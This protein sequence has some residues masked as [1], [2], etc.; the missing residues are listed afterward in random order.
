M[1]HADAGV[2]C[3]RASNVSCKMRRLCTSKAAI[4]STAGGVTIS[5]PPQDLLLQLHKKLDFVNGSEAARETAA[6]IDVAP[7][8]ERLRLKALSKVREFTMTRCK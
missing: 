8:L 7:E 2:D 1:V 3:V 4:L 6:Y 5:C